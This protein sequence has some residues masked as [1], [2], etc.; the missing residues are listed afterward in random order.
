MKG[1]SAEKY[2][3]VTGGSF[4]N[5]GAQAMTFITADQMA[6]RFP[7]C[8]M[9]LFSHYE[10]RLPESEKA[11][12]R[13]KFLR[14]PR[15]MQ[16]LQL[17]LGIRNEYTDIFRNAAALLDISGYRLGS[18]WG[19]SSV[20][21]YLNK[22][23]LAMRFGIP[24]YLMPQS[25]GPFD[26]HGFNSWGLMGRIRRTLSRC[27]LV[28][29]R[30]KESHSLLVDGFRL[31]NA[32]LAPDLVLQAG[33]IDEASIFAAPREPVRIQV[34]AGA[35]AVI[36]NSRNSEYGRR[37]EIMDVYRVL[38]EKLRKCGR[39]VYVVAHSTEDSGLCHE[40]KDRF[41]AQ[42]DG[43][44]LVETELNC[45]D[46]CAFVAQFDFIVASRFHSIVHAYKE[47]V[48]AL[49]LGWADKYRELADNMG[50]LRFFHD[51]RGHLDIDGISRDIDYLAEHHA[52]ESEAIGKRL[53]G[54]QENS[55]YGLIRTRQ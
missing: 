25:F 5:K 23:E 47:Q 28:M 44:A 26:F 22:L 14:F 12:Y 48:P 39:K 17:R 30:E 37:E 15:K 16:R 34:D 29:A 49:I 6:R 38:L 52:G 18:N 54:I 8:Q 53:A 31:G 42:D 21:G 27:S 40:I 41:A 24:V 50:Q 13:I 35:V 33:G 45:L 20:K 19:V 51:V 7:E 2:I 4:I 3:L 55:V 46:F 10:A 11:R 9:V 32:L 1:Q 43:V 36:P